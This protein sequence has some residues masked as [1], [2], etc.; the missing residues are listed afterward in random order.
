MELYQKNCNQIIERMG[1]VKVIPVLAI[2]KVEDGIC[3]VGFPTIQD[4][5]FTILD[6]LMENLETVH[7]ADFFCDDFAP[8]IT[9]G[10]NFDFKTMK[11][12]VFYA[13]EESFE[14]LEKRGDRSACRSYGRKGCRRGFYPR[15]FFW[16]TARYSA[17]DKT[18]A[19]HGM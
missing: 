18:R 2:E 5:S 16:G 4:L 9:V 8:Q 11:T 10:K 14:L 17:S 19:S 7:I 15:S 13:Q 12:S 6:V 3:I 1:K